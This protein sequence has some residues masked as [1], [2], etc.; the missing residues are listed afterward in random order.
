MNWNNVVDSL[1]EYGSEVILGNIKD[2]EKYFAVLHK[3]END[4]G[5]YWFYCNGIRYITLSDRWIKI[6]LPQLT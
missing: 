1:P 6:N 5:D 2:N 3:R 4:K